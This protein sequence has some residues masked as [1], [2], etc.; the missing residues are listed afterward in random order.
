MSKLLEV[1]EYDSIIGNVNYKDDDN[2]IYWEAF[3][4][5]VDFVHEFSGDSET[6]DVLDF[7]K[8]G[9]KRN[10]GKYVSI[11]NYVGLIQMKNG[12]QIQVLPK[13]D[14]GEPEQGSTRTKEIFLKMLRS[15]KD[16]PVKVFNDANLRVDRMNLYE[17]FINMYLQEVSQLVKRG[18][19]SNYVQQEENLGF[20]K[21]KLLVNQHIKE[22]TTHKERFYV[23]FEEFHPNGPENRLVKATLIKLQK[24]TGSAENSKKIRQLL[25]AFELVDAS[26]NYE[27]DFSKVV[28]NR[29]TKNYESLI[30]WSKVFLLNK[31][32]T[33]FTGS[34]NSRSLLFP[35]ESVYESYVAQQMKKVF[36]PDGWD[37]SSQDRG[38]YLFEEPRRKFAL[39]PDI[40]IK[41]DGRTVILDTKWKRLYDNERINYGISQAD[42][43]QMYAYSKKYKTPDVWLLYPMND[44]MRSH[45]PI[46]FYSGDETTVRLFFVDLARIE[47]SLEEL[48]GRIR[49]GDLQLNRS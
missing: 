29:N 44:S 45:E 13:I 49:A 36:R 48:K 19:R 7:L 25:T 18:I 23:S 8:V 12:H 42:M 47:D 2:Y 15:M 10:I 43:Y 33:T 1:R 35:M 30:K 34:S 22:N 24:L 37:V 17:V 41:K 32:F 46:E 4:S 40:V 39:R 20:Y 28:I 27:Q 3:D 6:S 11:K 38:Y 16:F 5:L 31:S 21:G 14:L 26:T 9:F